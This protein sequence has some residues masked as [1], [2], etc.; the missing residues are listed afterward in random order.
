M[1]EA[2]AYIHREWF[3]H[4]DVKP[5]NILVVLEG[6]ARDFL[7]S[8]CYFV[9]SY[10]AKEKHLSYFPVRLGKPAGAARKTV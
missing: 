4:L 5:H 9:K 8:E 7:W 2:L 10:A 3:A 6:E 1:A